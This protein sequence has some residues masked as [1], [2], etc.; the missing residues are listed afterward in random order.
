MRPRIAKGNL[1]APGKDTASTNKIMEGK[2]NGSEFSLRWLLRF[3][4]PCN[5][6]QLHFI[7]H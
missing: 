2:L 4:F 6:L 1:D 7:T 3:E 5:K